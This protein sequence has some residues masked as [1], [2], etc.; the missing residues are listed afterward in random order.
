MLAEKK[1]VDTLLKLK[2]QKQIPNL[3]YIIA[4]DED[5]TES[6]LELAKK[7]DI[8]IFKFSEVLEAGASNVN[9][10]LKRPNPQSI[11]MFC[12]TSGT[13]GDPKGAKIH[14]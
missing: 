11:Y 14:H 1:N 12:Y 2:E 6:T 7:V 3:K 13:T 4:I 8:K 9:I 10:T 5:L